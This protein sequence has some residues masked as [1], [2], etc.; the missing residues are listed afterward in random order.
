MR[1]SQGFKVPEARIEARC[2]K[3]AVRFSQG[4]KVPAGSLAGSESR[5]EVHTVRARGKEWMGRV[6]FPTVGDRFAPVAF[7]HF[8]GLCTTVAAL[9]EVEHL[10]VRDSPKVHCQLSTDS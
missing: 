2:P 8:T 7:L 5:Q 10:R 4:F 6:P 9:L 1:F 3:R